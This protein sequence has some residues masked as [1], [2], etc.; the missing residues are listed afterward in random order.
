VLWRTVRAPIIA[1]HGDTE[2][3]E[4]LIREAIELAFT[5]DAPLLQADALCELGEILALTGRRPEAVIS[6][7]EA[8]TLWEA[9]GDRVSTQRARH[10]A[11]S[12]AGQIQSA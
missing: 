3:A 10:R 2:H 5:A 7:E 9:K 4:S 11:A 1:R 12:L 6:F 8:A